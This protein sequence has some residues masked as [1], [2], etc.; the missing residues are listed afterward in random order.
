MSL[1]FAHHNCFYSALNEPNSL[2]ETLI[3]IYPGNIC[4]QVES[5]QCQGYPNTLVHSYSW[6]KKNIPNPGYVVTIS[7]MRKCVMVHKELIVNRSAYNAVLQVQSNNV[8]YCNWNFFKIAKKKMKNKNK[9]K[10]KF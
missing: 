3:F 5:L 8:C 1:H 4:S 7:S 10:N 6:E 2:K 9:T